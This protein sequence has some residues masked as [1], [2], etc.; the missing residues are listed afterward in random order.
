MKLLETYLLMNLNL[1]SISGV[2]DRSCT[3]PAEVQEE[4]RLRLLL[5]HLALSPSEC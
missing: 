4:D 1:Q 2:D 3:A 5:Q